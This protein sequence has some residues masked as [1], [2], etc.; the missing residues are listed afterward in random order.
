MHEGKKDRCP[1]TALLSRITALTLLLLAPLSSA[2][3]QDD[4]AAALRRI[5]ANGEY[6]Q[7]FPLAE[8]HEPAGEGAALSRPSQDS[9]RRGLNSDLVLFLSVLG[10]G[11][12]FL[13]LFVFLVSLGIFLYR[14]AR[15]PRGASS[16]EGESRA[17]PARKMKLAD[18]RLEVQRLRESGD[19][20]AAMHLL[21]LSAIDFGGS[22]GAGEDPAA[23]SREL[24]RS[25]PR[26]R[27]ESSDALAVL[28]RY[29]ELTIFG[30]RSLDAADLDRG[31]EA[32][33]RYET[34][35]ESG[36]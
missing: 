32:F 20:V 13:V 29:V 9:G 19:Y 5:L 16:R 24:L 36:R 17:L 7:E 8:G 25:W 1:G 35:L 31:L 2:L 34:A 4:P 27:G 15:S 30:S 28:V 6:Q 23:T 3:A 26:D 21:L 22:I 14:L 10:R 18:P 11:I 33:N 12:A